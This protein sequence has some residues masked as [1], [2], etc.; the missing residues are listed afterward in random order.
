MLDYVGRLRVI[1]SDAVVG[2]FVDYGDVIHVIE[3][4]LVVV[5]TSADRESRRSDQ[6]QSP[7]NRF[8]S[9]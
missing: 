6:N 9:V 1:A 3:T 2:V 5:A 4:F 8:L 7:H